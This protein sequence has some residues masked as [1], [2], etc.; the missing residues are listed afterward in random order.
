MS[1]AS[2]NFTPNF[3]TT[4]NAPTPFA[5]PAKFV[6]LGNHLVGQAPPNEN[7]AAK[8]KTRNA[9]AKQTGKRLRDMTDEERRAF[10][11]RKG[12]KIVKPTSPGPKPVPSQAAR[13]LPSILNPFQLRDQ[14]L[15]A[16]VQL[17]VIQP[18]TGGGWPSMRDFDAAAA[19]SNFLCAR[20]GEACVARPG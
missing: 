18:R 17:G 19:A 8:A 5:P 15:E 4:A 14:L 16:A 3:N 1:S 10:L 12:V 13:N 2:F 6:Q 7:R 9:G 20:A 11:K